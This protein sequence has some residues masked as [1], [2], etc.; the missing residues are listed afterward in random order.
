MR[1]LPGS[2]RRNS[3]IA[4]S[5]DADS[6][7]SDTPARNKLKTTI[8]ER[9]ISFFE[10]KHAVSSDDLWQHRLRFWTRSHMVKAKFVFTFVFIDALQSLKEMCLIRNAN[11]GI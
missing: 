6:T 9:L 10:S 8:I 7:S 4:R 3:H 2:R 11:L 5:H 1:C